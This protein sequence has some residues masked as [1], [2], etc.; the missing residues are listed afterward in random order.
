MFGSPSCA[1]LRRT[2]VE[3]WQARPTLAER[4]FPS[5]PRSAGNS[6][7]ADDVVLLKRR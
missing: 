3:Y 7:S 1:C 4:Y 2:A 6:P 5:L